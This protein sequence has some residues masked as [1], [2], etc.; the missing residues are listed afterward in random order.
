MCVVG[1]CKENGGEEILHE[2]KNIIHKLKLEERF[3]VLTAECLGTCK[4]RPSVMVSDGLRKFYYGNT[5]L[6]LI[7]TIIKYHMGLD[8]TEEN[9]RLNL[10]KVETSD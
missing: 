4:H 10:V 9:V 6:P 1:C 5:T 3:E 7:E 2:A 8:I